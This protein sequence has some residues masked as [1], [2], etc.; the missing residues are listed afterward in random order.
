MVVML[1]VNVV[2]NNVY[3]AYPMLDFLQLLYI[4]VFVSF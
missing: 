4:L 1:L 3:L 2:F